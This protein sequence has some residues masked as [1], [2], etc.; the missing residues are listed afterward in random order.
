M[1][2]LLTIEWYF[3]LNAFWTKV[4]LFGTGQG[5]DYDERFYHIFLAN[6]DGPEA[7]ENVNRFRATLTDALRCGLAN[8]VAFSAILGRAGLL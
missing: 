5:F 4:S 8:S 7:V 3:L 2:T 1:I 6:R